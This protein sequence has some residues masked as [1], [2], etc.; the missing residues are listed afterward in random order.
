VIHA[1]GPIWHGGGAGEAELLASAYRTALRLAGELGARTITFP[2]ISTGVYGYP[3]ESAAR[4]A[5]TVVRDHVA[6]KTTLERAT[7]VLFSGDAFEAFR[8]ALENT[9][10]PTS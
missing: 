1:V 9:A 3:I 6:G 2:A 4:V 7:F 5:L 8:Q 10:H